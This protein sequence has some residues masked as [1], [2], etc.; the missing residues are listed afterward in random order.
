M[1]SRQPRRMALKILLLPRS[2]WW[3]GNE[4]T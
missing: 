2:Q 3:L 4:L 1:L